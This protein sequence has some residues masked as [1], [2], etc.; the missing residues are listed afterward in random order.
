MLR[1]R[2]VTAYTRLALVLPLET[3]VRQIVIKAFLVKQ[4]NSGSSAL[5]IRMALAT[6]LFFQPAVIACTCPDIRSNRFVASQAKPGLC[7]T[8]KSHM[9]G[10]APGFIFRMPGDDFT[11]HDDGFKALGVCRNGKSQI[12]NQG[13][14]RRPQDFSKRAPQPHAQLP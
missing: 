6:N 4:Y 14:R 3:E 1:A 8:I 11:R 9:T 13:E 2:L 7:I 10:S 12:Q 5:V